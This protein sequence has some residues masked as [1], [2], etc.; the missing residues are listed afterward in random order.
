[1]IATGK[2]TE[3]TSIV[4]STIPIVAIIFGSIHIVLFLILHYRFKKELLLKGK[5]RDFSLNDLRRFLLL[6]GLLSIAAG[7]PL[8]FLFLFIYGIRPP[9]LG[10]AIP[11]SVGIAL[12]LFYLFTRNKK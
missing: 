4:I 6:C 7:T 12:I 11:L 3:I 10:G 1:M 8:T 2:A 5:Y 9:I